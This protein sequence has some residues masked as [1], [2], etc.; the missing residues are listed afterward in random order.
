[1]AVAAMILGIVSFI[2]SIL[3]WVLATSVGQA[4]WAFIILAIL[5]GIGAIVLAAISMKRPGKKGMKVVG[6]VFGIIGLAVSSI[7]L[8]AV[9]ACAASILG[10]AS[11]YSGYYLP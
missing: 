2:F 9:I 8:I 10:A 7:E 11:K 6:L 4:I 3:G 1:M 5:L